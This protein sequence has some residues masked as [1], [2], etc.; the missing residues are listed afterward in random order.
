MAAEQAVLVP[1]HTRFSPLTSANFVEMLTLSSV[2]EPPKFTASNAQLIFSVVKLGD[3]EELS[4]DR[5]QEALR[6]V[7]AQKHASY[8]EIAEQIMSRTLKRTEDPGEIEEKVDPA[9]GHPYFVN[10][11][12]GKSA[13]LREEVM[14]YSAAPPAAPPASNATAVSSA[15]SLKQY[16]AGRS[17]W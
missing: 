7:A 14:R 15:A 13:W 16:L 9:S 10:N 11:R 6:Q 4:V 1:L 8:D 17:D 3:R 2:L 5:L 12:T